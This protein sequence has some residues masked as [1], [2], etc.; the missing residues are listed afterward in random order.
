MVSTRS[1]NDAACSAPPFN[2]KDARM[3]DQ[4]QNQAQA[5]PRLGGGIFLFV[6]LLVGSI[7]GIALNEPS[8]G[9]ISGFG[10]G[11]LLAIVIWLLDSKR[12]SKGR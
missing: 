12:G 11:G 4:E 1:C 8:I 10:V 2:G 3:N 9:M 7:A 6:G 5:R